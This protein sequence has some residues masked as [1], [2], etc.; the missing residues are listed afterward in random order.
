MGFTWKYSS[1]LHS[2]F[3]HGKNMLTV[4]LHTFMVFAFSSLSNTF[5]SMRLV[6]FQ[7]DPPSRLLEDLRTKWNGKCQQWWCSAEHFSHIPGLSWSVISIQRCSLLIIDSGVMEI[8]CSSVHLFISFWICHC[9]KQGANSSVYLCIS[10]SHGTGRDEWAAERCYSIP[11]HS[12]S[13]GYVQQYTENS[14]EEK[15]RTFWTNNAVSL[16]LYA[17]SSKRECSFYQT[18]NKN[19]KFCPQLYNGFGINPSPLSGRVNFLSSLAVG[20]FS[21]SAASLLAT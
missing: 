6:F 14:D 18:N 16:V 8:T 10:P 21:T 5:H 7:F 12:G 11:E 9:S 19:S 2:K 1:A 17:V 4:L 3:D 20:V 13:S 15:L